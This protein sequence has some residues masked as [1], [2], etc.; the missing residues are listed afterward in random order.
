MERARRLRPPYVCRAL[1]RA[2]SWVAPQRARAAWREKWDSNLWNW[3]ILFER[4]ELS[5]SDHVELTRYCWGSFADAFRL[6]VSPSQLRH[7]VRGPGTV[8]ASA[9]VALLLMAGLTHGFRNTRALFNP[10]PLEDPGSLVD[11]RYSGALDEPFGI[12]PRLAPLWNS[13]SRLLSGLAGFVH[14]RDQPGALVTCNFFQ[15]M[16]VKPAL[17]RLFQPGDTD[18]AIVSGGA[19]RSMY[20]SDPHV[21]G[22]TVSFE[23][24]R[25][26]IIGVL[27]N[28]F[29]ALRPGIDIWLPL[30][31][32][33]PG[34]EVP[35]LIGAVARLKRG[36]STSAVRAELFSL[37]GDYFLPRPPQ[38]LSFSAIPSAPYGPYAFGLA[39]ALIVGAVLIARALPRPSGSGWHYWWFL[40]VKTL[41]LA[42]LPTLAWMELGSL[43]VKTMPPGLGRGL[44]FAVALPLAFVFA[45]AVSLWWSFADQRRRCPICLQRLSLP[46]TMGSWGSVLDPSATEML[47]D[48]GHGSLCASE[49]IGGDTDRWTNLDKSWGDLFGPKR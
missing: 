22:R 4:G 26:K 19:W 17:G 10:L 12:P 33:P 32:D 31:L 28:R 5:A 35:P 15:V 43:V 29:W 27:P 8:L 48:A 46:V 24:G 47:C 34:P 45:F 20:A 16:G 37:R 40:A 44:L 23:G 42:A 14:H 11:I 39:F 25:Y 38:V 41:A 1:V 2:A 3:W 49:A 18:V 36:V 6:R 30:R 21:I 13:K 9:A 7:A